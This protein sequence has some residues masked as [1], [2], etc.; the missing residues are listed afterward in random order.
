MGT[1]QLGSS[2]SSPSES[3]W[4]LGLDGRHSDKWS[5]SVYITV[6]KTSGLPMQEAQI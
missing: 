1:E 5:D 3:W 6:S 2:Y 4:W